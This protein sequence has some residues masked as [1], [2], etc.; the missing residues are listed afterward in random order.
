[1]SRGIRE[2]VSPPRGM[3]L[4]KSLARYGWGGLWLQVVVG[5]ITAILLVYFMILGRPPTQS[6]SGVPFVEYL[7]IADLVLLAVSTYWSYRYTKLA[8][9]VASPDQRPPGKRVI[10]IVWTGVVI[11]T[12][13]MVFS[14][15]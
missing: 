6:R 2:T 11:S 13:G 8:R 9:R 3:S 15:I 1:M 10:G 14:M 4:A 7:T 12:A 5:S